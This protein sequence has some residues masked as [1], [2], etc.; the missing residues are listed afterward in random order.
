MNSNSNDADLSMF[1]PDD[2]IEDCLNEWRFSLIGR[3]DLVKLTM[4]TVEA[5]LR[6]HWDVK[7]IIQ[8]IPL[9]KGFFIIK[10]DNEDDRNMIWKGHWIVESQ[11]SKLRAWEPNF[12]PENQKITSAFVWVMFPGLS[13]EY[14]KE[15]IILKMGNKVGRDIRVDETTLKRE[16]G[17]YAS[18][19]VEVDITKPNPSKINIESKYGKFE[20]SIQIPKLPKFCIHCSVIGHHVAECRNKTE[21]LQELFETQNSA[22]SVQQILELRLPNMNK[23]IIHNTSATSKGNLWLLW[24][25]SI[26]EP[27]VISNTKQAITVD[28]VGHLVTGVHASNF[29]IHRRVLWEELSVISTFNKPWMIIGDYNAVLSME[30]K[31]GGRNPLTTAMLEFNKY[32]QNC[33]LMQAPK[34]R[35]EYSWCNNRSGKK[36]IVCNLD[37]DFYN[38]QWLSSF[39]IW[40][41]KVRTRG[42]SDHNSIFGT[43]ATIPKPA[44]V[45][46]R[47]LKVWM[48]HED[49]RSPQIEVRGNS[50]FIFLTKLKHIKVILKKWNWDV[51]RDVNKRLKKADEEVL[52]QSL[53]SDQSPHNIALL[54]N[55][56][57]ARGVQELLTQQKQEI[58]RQKARV[59]WLKFGAANTKFFHVNMKIRQVHN[60]IVELEKDDGEL[61]EDNKKLETIPSAAEIKQ[62]VFDL[63][64]DSSPGPDG[65]GGWFYRMAWE[66]ISEDFIKA[67]QYCREKEFIPAATE[68]PVIDHQGD[69]RIWSATSSGKFFVSSS[70]NCIRKKIQPVNWAKTVW[71]KSVFPN[72]SGNVWKILRKV[73]PTDE[74]MKQKKFQIASRCPFCNKE[75]ENTEH[76]L[77][78]CEFSELTW[79]WLGAIR[80]PVLVRGIPSLAFEETELAGKNLHSVC[81]IP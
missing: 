37:R 27:M 80:T 76:I 17:F 55:L 36:R 30:E 53:I 45:P 73:V 79:S 44:N 1:I 21:E 65:F 70:Y 59:K 63:D 62:A 19:L 15:D 7:G 74:T 69:R 8:L 26:K 61:N 34:T 41:Y 23:K 42:T 13:I 18:V 47:A 68:L 43:N 2:V 56:V 22:L 66:I 35:L 12:N 38:V 72:V 31:K 58:E 10:L 25:I 4:E 28:V 81:M 48:S 29:T 14:W 39:P 64:P 71:H 52:K 49:F 75:E 24:N 33:E 77:W 16:S 20:Q 51:F 5:S 6:K 54:N 46:F 3:L 32:I 60:A 67:I 78:F 50:G 40:G 9:G 57:T 11:D